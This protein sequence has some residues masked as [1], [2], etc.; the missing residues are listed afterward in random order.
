MEAS[1]RESVSTGAKLEVL[2]MFG[3]LDFTTLLLI[4]TWQVF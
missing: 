3:L 1:S 2:G 4:L